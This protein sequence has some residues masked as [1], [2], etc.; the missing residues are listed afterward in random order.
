LALTATLFMPA[1][2]PPH[3]PAP[4]ASGYHRFAMVALA[5]AGH[6]GWI[7]SDLELV[8]SGRSYTSATL[9]TFKESGWSPSEL[10][11]ILGADAFAEIGTWHAFPS[12]LDDANFVVVSR[13]GHPVSALA[14][15]HPGLAD[16]M[17]PPPLTT[18]S[19]PM[20]VLID[21]PTADVSATA[22]RERVARGE[23]I[24]RMVPLAIAQ[25]IEQHRLYVANAAGARAMDPLRAE[26]AGRLHGQD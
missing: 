24:A 25:H 21:A 13:P 26:A 4:L 7:A 17:T 20:I 2:V 16:R 15:R 6:P 9:Q 12:F 18:G 11:F 10:F 22:I 19:R 8:H 14:S 23:S 5:V 3:R 1:D